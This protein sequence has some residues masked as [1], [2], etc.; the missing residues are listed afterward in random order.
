M[1]YDE[2]KEW[3]HP[4][5]SVM[6][7]GG[8]RTEAFHALLSANGTDVLLPSGCDSPFTTLQVLSGHEMPV[9]DSLLVSVTPPEAL[10][11]VPVESWNAQENALPLYQRPH[12]CS[13]LARLLDR[14]IR[15]GGDALNA[16]VRAFG[17]DSNGID[18][19]AHCAICNKNAST[20]KTIATESMSAQVKEVEATLDQLRRSV[21]QYKTGLPLTMKR[22]FDEWCPGASLPLS[23]LTT[24]YLDYTPTET[25]WLVPRKESVYPF[26]PAFLSDTNDR[27]HPLS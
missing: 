24:G 22:L 25:R 20:P 23:V 15:Y 3:I 9:F 19:F 11:Y 6:G 8:W 14:Y 13:I 4:L 10:T 1:I 7:G 26:F 18:L 16:V 27:S 12:H 17:V 2:Y 5:C 21:R